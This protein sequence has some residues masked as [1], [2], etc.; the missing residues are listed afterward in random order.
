MDQLASMFFKDWPSLLRVVI[1]SLV[2]YIALVTCLRVS[3]KRTLS[4]MNAFDLVITVALGSTFATLVLSKDVSI[5]EGALAFAMLV[6]LQ[7]VVAWLAVRSK[8]FSQAVKSEPTLVFYRGQMRE[9]A[10]RRE[11]VTEGEVLAAIREQGIATIDEVEAVVLEPAGE[12][13]VVRR[14]SGPA[15]TLRE[16]DASPAAER[17]PRA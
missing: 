12:M 7:Y 11:R 10:L 16:L 15:T 9:D 17:A 3:G 13:S 6:M 2:G 4:K 1:A 14:A 8:G 5:T